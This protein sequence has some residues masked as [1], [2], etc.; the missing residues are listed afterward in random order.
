[1]TAPLLGRSEDGIIRRRAL[2]A[3]FTRLSGEKHEGRRE[4]THDREDGKRHRVALGK[5][6]KK[7]G[8]YR[9]HESP[10]RGDRTADALNRGERLGAE[11]VGAN[12]F[13]QGC[14][15]AISK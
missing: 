13:L 7:P 9:S 3:L 2:D 8:N 5:V 12:R 15:A 14:E 10:G 4:Q 1:V 6:I 11:I